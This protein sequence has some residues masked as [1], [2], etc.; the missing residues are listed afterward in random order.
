MGVPIIREA[1]Q[2]LNV[3]RVTL[4][5]VRQFRTE[6]DANVRVRREGRIEGCFSKLDPI[7]SGIAA[8]HPKCASTS[9]QAHPGIGI[10]WSGII[11]YLRLVSR[12]ARRQTPIDFV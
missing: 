7:G 9:S 6:M 8:I 1:S 11:C 4:G 3:T 5:N 10:G 12:A 2:F